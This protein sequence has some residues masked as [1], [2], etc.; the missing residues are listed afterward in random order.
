[1][2][3]SYQQQTQRL[4]RDIA[5]KDINPRDLVGYINEARTQV[6]GESA[7]IRA[8]GTLPVVSANRGP[9][10]FSLVTLTTA[11][12][13]GILDARAFLYAVGT[14]MKWITPRSFEWFTI[15]CLNN[16][17]PGTGAPKVWSQYGQGVTGSVYVDPVP[18][19]NYTLS[20]DCVCYPVPLVNDTTIE[21]VAP[22]WTTAVPYYAAYLALLS[23]QTGDYMDKAQKMLSLYELFV[24]RARRFVTPDVL[25]LQYSQATPEPTATQYTPPQGQARPA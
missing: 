22:L 2:L 11:G 1:M 20:G 15:Y 6:A 7:S 3:F 23:A 8:F 12:V 25:P 18:D 5:Q 17:N 14:G 10:A 19:A 4:I 21:A 16:T 24:A 9:Y 13:A